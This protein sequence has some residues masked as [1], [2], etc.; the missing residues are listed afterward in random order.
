M[1]HWTTL[2][3]GERERDQGTAL[4]SGKPA[5]RIGSLR[6][7]PFEDNGLAKMALRIMG[8][9]V[10]FGFGSHIIDKG[11]KNDI[12]GILEHPEHHSVRANWDRPHFNPWII[13]RLYQAAE[14]LRNSVSVSER[15]LLRFNF[16]RL[17]RHEV[18]H[19]VEQLS[20]L[21]HLRSQNTSSLDA[22]A[23]HPEI[24]LLD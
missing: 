1:K 2:I 21:Q 3:F 4:T 18:A 7:H 15:E 20:L 17:L 12:W 24:Y 23:N 9:Q 14:E 19:A 11:A 13:R 6:N 10:K 5:V 16:V 8:A 22:A